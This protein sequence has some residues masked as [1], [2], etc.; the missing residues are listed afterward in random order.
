VSKECVLKNKEK[1]KQL[2]CLALHS[3]RKRKMAK[4]SKTKPATTVGSKS[5]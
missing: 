4:K 3:P 5:I 2:P 1:G